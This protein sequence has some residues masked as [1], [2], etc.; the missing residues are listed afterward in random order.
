MGE[1]GATEEQELPWNV[2][3]INDRKYFS[4]DFT[5]LRTRSEHISQAP[6]QLVKA[7]RL[8]FIPHNG[9][10]QWGD[11]DN[12]VDCWRATG[13]LPK[14]QLQKVSRGRVPTLNGGVEG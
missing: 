4:E 3:D 6:Y 12:S 5:D 1:E 8:E 2:L 14:I 10:L 11:F 7:G 13:G 9:G